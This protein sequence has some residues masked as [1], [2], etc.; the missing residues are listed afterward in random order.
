LFQVKTFVDDNP[1]NGP[2][3]P[4]DVDPTTRVKEIRVE[5]G[6]AAPTPGWQ[7]AIPARVVLR[8]TAGN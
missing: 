1:F 2:G 4:A 7:T 6:L 8:R 3:S 5:V